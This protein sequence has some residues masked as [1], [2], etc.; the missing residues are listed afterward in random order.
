MSARA[1][2]HRTCSFFA[3]FMPKIVKVGGNFMKF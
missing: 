1:L 2:V 3:I